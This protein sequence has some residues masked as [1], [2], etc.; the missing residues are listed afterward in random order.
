MKEWNGV[1]KGVTILDGLFGYDHGLLNVVQDDTGD[2][3]GDGSTLGFGVND[4]IWTHSGWEQIPMLQRQLQE[5]P[6]LQELVR[7]LGRRPSAKDSDRMNK[8]TPRKQDPDGGLGA[9]F[10]PQIRES[11]TGIT[12]S[13]NLSEM[14]PSEAVLLRGSKPVLRTLFLAKWVESKLISY[15]L[16]GYVDVPSV[17]RTRPLYRNRLPSAPGG[18][19]IVCLDTSWSMS[20][21]RENLAKAVVLACVTQA[22]KQKRDCQVVAFSTERQV[23][24]SGIITANP[25]GVQRLLAFLSHSFGGGTDVTGALKYAITSLTS[26]S[27]GEENIMRSA[28]IL[29]VTDGEIPDPPV[30]ED[31]MRSLD[32]LKIKE[33]AEI[34]GLLVG[35]SESKPLTR[36][37]THT[38]DFLSRYYD[39]TKMGGGAFSSITSRKYNNKG[40]ISTAL[41]AAKRSYYDDDDDFVRGTKNRKNGKRS[42]NYVYDE[43]DNDFDNDGYSVVRKEQL[44][45]SESFPKEVEE[46]LT[47]LKQ[48]ASEAVM[49]N[50]WTPE[51]LHKERAE[52]GTCWEAHKQL[53]SAVKRVEQG[54]VERGEDARLVVLA[55]VANEHILLLGSP[56]TAKSVLGLRLAMLCD[57]FFFQ[58]LLTRFTTPEELFGPLSLRSLENDEY[59]RVTAGFLPTADIAFLDEIF[60]ANSAILNTLLT[61][62]NER[63]FDNAGSRVPCPIRCVVGASNELPESD[64]LVALFD[65]FLI[66]K[67]VL[68]V[69]DDGVLKLLAMANPGQLDNND[70]GD[71]ESASGVPFIGDLD[72]II[73]SL[74]AAADDVVMEEDACELMRDLRTYMREN[75]NVEIS[76][77]RL[78]KTT[79]LLKICAASDGRKKV[80]TID[81][82][83]TQHCFWNEPEQRTAIRDWLWENLT[84]L[85][86]ESGS[87]IDQ[88]RFILDNL[89][90]DVVSA[91]RKTSGKIDTSTGARMEDVAV[92]DSLRDECNQIAMIIQQQQNGLARHLELVRSDDFT[93]VDPDDAYAMR[94]LLLP[95][96]ELLMEEISQLSQ[97]AQ[98]LAMAISS[99]NPMDLR[100]DL[101]IDV[102]EMIWE[103]DASVDQEFSYEELQLSLKEA[104]SKYDGDTLRRWKRARKS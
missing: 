36:L 60:K 79:R 100:D 9:E 10:D 104:K 72:S 81:F 80:D 86:R 54:L 98:A 77:R 65:R 20:G 17:P 11:V 43:E 30:S 38:H 42:N 8:F 85:E 12:L 92:I 28:D 45:G 64:E 91:L 58:R 67:E 82:L 76:D 26:N 19:I 102:I 87:S 68:P 70:S 29:L 13:S 49:N 40:R 78:V 97:D 18:P 50:L 24:E 4:G 89:R 7:N 48:A 52:M 5:L 55:L 57:G 93:W 1:V 88:M 62:L 90:K 25:A 84:P 71:N 2:D 14:L 22:H 37:C 35:K 46:R 101:R 33:G 96:G 15:E 83:V 59:K 21:S 95:R 63:K 74:S 6:E 69:S 39:K 47:V 3:S 41:Y 75:Q 31:I 51:E 56:G 44:P 66:R 34:H 23:M 94:Q 73:K 32:R 99:T 27:K 16:S 53:N 61:I 103:N